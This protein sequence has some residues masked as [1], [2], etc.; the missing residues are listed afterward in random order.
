[1]PPS[2]RPPA[3]ASDIE[4]RIRLIR[5]VRVLLD[6]TLA[7]LYGVALR[8]LIQ[9]VERHPEWFPEDFAFRLDDGEHAVGGDQ[10]AAI[11]GEGRGV[12][13][14]RPWAFTEAGAGMLA[15][16]FRSDRAAAVT[17]EVLRGFALNRRVPAA[18]DEMSHLIGLLAQSARRNTQ[19][20]QGIIAALDEQA[21][22]GPVPRPVARRAGRGRT[23]L[24]KNSPEAKK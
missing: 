20:L 3:L 18:L 17:V 10:P 2:A 15:S 24:T 9:A 13:R 22:R 6:E 16:V 19:D 21:G 23:A 7:E 11:P 5:G 12:R 4:S 8:T 1:M 14:C